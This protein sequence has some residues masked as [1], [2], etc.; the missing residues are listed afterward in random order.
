[1]SSRTWSKTSSKTSETNGAW[2]FLFDGAF[3]RR[4]F[5]NIRRRKR[6]RKRHLKRRKL[7]GFGVFFFD[8]VFWRQ[9]VRR[10]GRRNVVSNVHADVTSSKTSTFWTTLR[11][12]SNRFD[13]Y[14]NTPRAPSKTSS[15]TSSNEKGDPDGR[16]FSNPHSGSL[17]NLRL[18][19]R[20]KRHQPG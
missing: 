13:N 6:G 20:L 10:F 14:S 16:Q 9:N 17:R 7:M 8:D 19:R 4:L 1:M 15:K 18:K 11:P 5:F 3:Y 12:V 2:G